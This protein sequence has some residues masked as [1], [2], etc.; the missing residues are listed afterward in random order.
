M[1]EQAS[2]EFT[3]LPG[4][5]WALD[6]TNYRVISVSRGTAKLLPVFMDLDL[7]FRYLKTSELTQT[8]TLL[9]EDSEI[10]F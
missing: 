2:F 4:Q 3:V 8:G 10:P 7:H 1:A 9:S 5:V 6:G